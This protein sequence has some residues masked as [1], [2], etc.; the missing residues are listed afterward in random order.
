MATFS[1]VFLWLPPPVVWAVFNLMAMTARNPGN[2][3]GQ[4]PRFLGKRAISVE[5]GYSC[6]GFW[7]E[8]HV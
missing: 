8:I 1:A 6:G 7:Y 4:W 5:M 3:L 2:G